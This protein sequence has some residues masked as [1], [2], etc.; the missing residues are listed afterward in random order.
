M[1]I[2]SKITLW[3]TAA[4]VIT[5]L[6]FSL[7]VFYELTEYPYEFIDSELSTVANTAVKSVAELPQESTSRPVIGASAFIE[8]YWIKIFDQNQRLVYESRMAGLVDLPFRKKNKGSNV[9]VNVPRNVINL[10]QERDE[11]VTFRVKPFKISADGRQFLVE[12]GKPVEGLGEEVA[13]LISALAIGFSGSVLILVAVS[14]IVAGRILKPIGEINGLAREI[15]DRSLDRRIPLGKSRDELYALSEALNRMFD[16][17]QYSFDRQKQFIA[18]ASHELKTPI[19]TLRLFFEEAVHWADLSD[20]HRQM[21]DSQNRVL[22]RMNRLVKAL[23]D[24]SALDLER[25]VKVEEIDLNALVEEIANELSPLLEAKKISLHNRLPKHMRLNA[26]EGKMRRM[27]INLLDNAIKYNWEGGE[28]EVEGVEAQDEVS[29]TFFN[30]GPGVANDELDRVFEQFYRVEKSR[31]QQHG[32]AGL[33]LSLVR[34]IVA[35]HGGEVTME[36]EPGAWV[37]VHVD[38][39]KKRDKLVRSAEL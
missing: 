13:E 17:L 35:L 33:G 39:P 37:R 10:G 15:N 11:E 25:T 20:S 18:N 38:L 30:T 36:S 1:K 3:V 16:R 4:G 7:V 14:Y 12:V 2:K 21:L 8:Q 5:S 27:L 34:Q 29:L 9:S 23:L 28:I 32:G 26:D 19:A 22:L 31:S 24:L 6:I